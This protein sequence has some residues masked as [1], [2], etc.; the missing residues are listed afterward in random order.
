[1]VN[2]IRRGGRA[3]KCESEG[4]GMGR[5]NRRA[6]G[7]GD[8]EKMINCWSDD[9]RGGARLGD[10]EKVALRRAQAEECVC[11]E[12]S[13]VLKAMADRVLG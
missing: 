1:M 11:L 10:D 9:C 4:A 13:S 3:K 8:S 5:R 7:G 2:G 6:R 12:A